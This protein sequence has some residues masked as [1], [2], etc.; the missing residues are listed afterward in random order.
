MTAEPEDFADR[1]ALWLAGHLAGTGPVRLGPFTRPG[2]GLSGLTY[3]VEASRSDGADQESQSLVVRLLAD[4]GDGLFQ[5]SDLQRELEFHR[6]LEQGHL[7]VAPLV[8][9]EES[10]EVLGSRFVVSRRVAGRVVDSN[11]PYLSRGWLH[12]APS[13]Y[14]NRIWHG[15]VDT[16]ADL[17]RISGDNFS[18]AGGATG[19]GLLEAALRRWAEYLD[20][21]GHEKAPG[22]LLEALD[23]CDH[24]R[25]LHEPAPSL[26]WGD[27]QLGNAV[28]AEDGSVAA[29]LDF[30]LASVGPA[31]LDLGWFI[32]LHDMT[33]A[34]CGQDLPGF[35]DR[36]GVLARYE[37]R[38]GRSM[39]DLEWFEIFAAV[40][41]ASI[42]VRMSVVLSAGGSDLSWLAR[43]NPALEYIAAR[44][45]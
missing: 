16:L 18:A 35:E 20:W 9:L 11:D 31:E 26:L 4:D 24:N 32:C 38:L 14:Q 13:S 8:G 7:P 43:S 27:A 15:F 5:R 17:H 29:L 19:P 39:L 1:L 25:P 33:V 22:A 42:L 30:E 45:G 28:F 6:L 34:R 37:E 23:W 41:T 10:D 40:C 12:D 2:S 21:V 36:N 3:L 44:L